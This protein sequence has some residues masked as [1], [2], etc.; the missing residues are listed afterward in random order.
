MLAVKTRRYKNSLISVNRTERFRDNLILFGKKIAQTVFL[1]IFNNI[2]R[3][4]EIIT[5]PVS[6][7]TYLIKV[8][9]TD[10]L[11]NENVGVQGSVNVNF[12]PLPPVNLVATASSVILTNVTLTWEHSVEGVPD[13]Y[14]IYS[15]NG[16]GNVIDKSTPLASVAGNVLSY[17]HTTP[18]NGVWKYI[19]EAVDTGLESN[20][21]NVAE[22]TIPYTAELPNKPGPG[23]LLSATG[24]SLENVSIGKVKLSFIWIYGADAA[25]FN[26]YYD[27]GT[28]TIDYNTPLQNITRVDQ[29]VQTGTTVRLHSTNEEITYK[30]AVRTVSPDG[31]EEQ[32]TDTYSI[33]VDGLEPDDAVDLTLDTV[34]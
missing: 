28:G 19:V 7:G 32:N 22:A 10:N 18:I 33:V 9:S 5:I 31:A 4:Y 11:G 30:F 15:N 2:Y 26:V 3:T 16:S 25:S 34:Y 17:V 20:N 21:Y 27:N 12:Y 24:I 23:G 1:T 6:N 13:T 29:L 8:T 14:N